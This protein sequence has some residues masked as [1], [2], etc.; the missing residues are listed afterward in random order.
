[1]LTWLVFDHAT[2]VS[3]A[4]ILVFDNVLSVR[5]NIFFL[6]FLPFI[7]NGKGGPLRS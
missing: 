4:L 1:M 5:I 3:V 6:L 7:Q 2:A